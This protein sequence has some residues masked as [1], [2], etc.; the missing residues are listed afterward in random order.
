[1]KDTDRSA[2]KNKSDKRPELQKYQAG[3]ALLILGAMLVAFGLFFSYNTFF[4]IAGFFI[5]T[6]IVFQF[7]K[8]RPAGRW[9]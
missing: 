8:N 5:V 7:D 2:A 1:M 9:W 4:I 3:V 6:G